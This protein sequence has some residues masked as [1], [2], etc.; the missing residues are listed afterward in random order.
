MR[1]LVI[2]KNEAG[3]RLDKYLKKYF[4]EAGSGFLYK[5]LRKKNILLNEKKAEG[6]EMLSEGDRITLYLAEETIEKFRKTPASEKES[7][8]SYP[9]AKLWI[10]YEDED[11]L[12]INKPAGMLSQKA[13]EQDVS[14][15]EYLIGYLLEEKRITARELETFHP[16]VCNRLDRNTSG[17]VLAGKTLKGLQFLSEI[18]KDR[19]LKKY[20]LCLVKGKISEKQHCRAYLRKDSA[21]NHVRVYDSPR[22]GAVLIE[23]AYEPCWSDG[24]VTLLQVE[25]I[26]GKSHQIRA[27]LASMGHPLAGDPRY[28]NRRWNQE[29]KKETGL[30]RQFLHAWKV[31]FPVIEG[32]GASLSERSVLAPLPEELER[33]LQKSGYGGK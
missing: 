20:Y 30:T 32:V 4:R 10:L 23:T 5:M 14:L 9:R 33:V 16:S 3:Q 18:L 13:S 7:S 12:M 29:L 31:E 25:L 17:I 11:I 21:A 22:E 28:G 27:H 24:K 1:K 2:G 8:L 19:T 15:V 26:T 6:K